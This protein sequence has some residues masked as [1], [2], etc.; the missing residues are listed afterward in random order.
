ML[1]LAILRTSMAVLS[2]SIA[3]RE[4][5]D[6]LLRLMASYALA[7]VSVMMRLAKRFVVERQGG[8]CMGLLHW[9]SF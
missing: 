1:G 8:I 7:L 3:V 6:L 9:A 2:F 5:T 4:K